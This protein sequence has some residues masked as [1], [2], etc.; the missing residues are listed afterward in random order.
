MISNNDKLDWVQFTAKF[1]RTNQLRNW[2]LTIVEYFESLYLRILKWQNLASN[3][4]P[5]TVSRLQNKY[6]QR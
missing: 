3:I 6:L 1:K 2:F 5:I 4:K